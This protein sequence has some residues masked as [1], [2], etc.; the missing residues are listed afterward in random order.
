MFASQSTGSEI[1]NMFQCFWYVCWHR[2][3][4]VSWSK[5][6]FTAPR[7]FGGMFQALS[8]SR[9]MWE[10]CCVV[11]LAHILHLW[12]V[13]AKQRACQANIH[14]RVLSDSGRLLLGAMAS[15]HRKA[16]I[17]AV[18]FCKVM[19]RQS[20]K[21]QSPFA[22]STFDSGSHPA[23]AG[24]YSTCLSVRQQ[25]CHRPL[26]VLA[27]HQ[28]RMIRAENQ[29]ARALVLSCIGFSFWFWCLYIYLIC[30]LMYCAK[31]AR[32][33]HGPGQKDFNSGHSSGW[34]F[35]PVMRH[36]HMASLASW[37]ICILA[38][39]KGFFWAASFSFIPCF[40]TTLR[41]GGTFQ[42]VGFLL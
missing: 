7:M 41:D 35:V 24:R 34:H 40:F 12:K 31:S 32:T 29:I 10:A 30:A 6:N 36:W 15:W 23:Q 42:P 8:G 17:G 2:L 13:F 1:P 4:A 37:V 5:R 38:A 19:E 11:C 26:F 20:S 28:A 9:G 3:F 18:I 22:I 33:S 27:F 21:S 16:T 14:Q 25:S 39:R